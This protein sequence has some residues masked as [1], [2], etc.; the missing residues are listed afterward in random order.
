MCGNHEKRHGMQEVGGSIPPGSTNPSNDLAGGAEVAKMPWQPCIFHN[1][2]SALSVQEI[3][4]GLGACWR[5]F[6]TLRSTW[7]C[8]SSI[9]AFNHRRA[10]KQQQDKTARIAAGR[11]SD[12]CRVIRSL[13]DACRPQ[14]DSAR[15][16]LRRFPQTSSIP[17]LPSC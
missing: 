12:H 2:L 13:P 16:N 6:P 10:G 15:G 3:H 8:C 9:E 14:R 17:C 4:F 7:A 11:F 5:S 1:F